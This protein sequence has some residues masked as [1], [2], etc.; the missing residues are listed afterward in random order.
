[1]ICKEFV[2][3]NNGT[4]EITSRKGAGS[5]FIVTLPSAAQE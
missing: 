3:K 5:S 2:E 1:V 4:L